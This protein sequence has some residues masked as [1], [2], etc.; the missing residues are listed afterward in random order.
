MS[1]FAFAGTATPGDEVIIRRVQID[2]ASG[3]TGEGGAGHVSDFRV[4]SERRTIADGGVWEVDGLSF[5]DRTPNDSTRTPVAYQVTTVGASGT[6]A[7]R[8][9][10]VVATDGPGPHD[11]AALAVFASPRLASLGGGG[12]PTA[13]LLDLTGTLLKST[14]NGVATDEDL[15]P[16]LDEIEFPAQVE[17]VLAAPH[18]PGTPIGVDGPLLSISYDPAGG[19]T[20]E[21][22]AV[23]QVAQDGAYNGGT[24]GVLSWSIPGALIV[25]KGTAA[26]TGTPAQN[27]GLYIDSAAG[28]LYFSDGTVWLPVVTTVDPDSTFE[29]NVGEDP[30]L[31]GFLASRQTIAAMSPPTA[32]SAGRIVGGELQLPPIGFSVPIVGENVVSVSLPGPV[33]ANRWNVIASYETTVENP[34]QSAQAIQVRPT[35]SYQFVTDSTSLAITAACTSWG[36]ATLLPDIT[37]YAPDVFDTAPGGWFDSDPAFS[38]ANRTT[39]GGF[40]NV[41]NPAPAGTDWVDGTIDGWVFGAQKG[42]GILSPVPG[43]LGVLLPGEQQTIIVHILAGADSVVTGT[44][45]YGRVVFGGLALPL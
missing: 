18:T 41:V 38:A 23:W 22:Q 32:R 24:P 9:V 17:F 31:I 7:D 15:A 19:P 39:F 14:V 45:I 20:G 35:V 40:N 34:P 1:T 27:D 36:T 30:S 21:G 26:P 25:P 37:T 6:D 5:C 4:L 12:G 11:P 2:T 8:L 43:V 42:S 28:V 3:S 33:G 16:L 44:A 10:R 13:N 29:P